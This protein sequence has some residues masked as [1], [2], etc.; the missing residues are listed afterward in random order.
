MRLEKGVLRR[1]E[2]KGD[3]YYGPPR[4]AF[5]VAKQTDCLTGRKTH[6]QVCRLVGRQADR[7]VGG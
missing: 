6:R 1:R 7:Q 5:Y 2:G 3:I 4:G